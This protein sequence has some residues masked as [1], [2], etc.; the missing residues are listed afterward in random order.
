MPERLRVQAQE[1]QRSAWR[2]KPPQQSE[3]Y[4]RPANKTLKRDPFV[5][6]KYIIA[7]KTC[8]IKLH[9]AA[10]LLFLKPQPLFGSYLPSLPDE[11][12]PS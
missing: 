12:V 9:P 2:Y 4:S 1:I 3:N 10:A 7:V 6:V 8:R 5:S 11:P